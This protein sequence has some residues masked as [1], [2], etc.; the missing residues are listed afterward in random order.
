MRQ[1]VLERE[2]NKETVIQS[3]RVCARVRARA[4]VCVCVFCVCVVCVCMF[5]C[6]CRC[7]GEEGNHCVGVSFVL[8]CVFVC[9]SF[10]C[11]YVNL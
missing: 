5:V 2:K 11:V 4:C 3:V 7:V 10:V 9:D 8:A 6:M 1:C